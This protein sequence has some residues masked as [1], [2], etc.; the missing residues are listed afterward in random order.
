MVYNILQYEAAE[1]S[2]IQQRVGLFSRMQQ[3]QW[4]PGGLGGPHSRWGGVQ[5]CVRL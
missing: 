4:F 5:Q 3:T 2:G 1:R